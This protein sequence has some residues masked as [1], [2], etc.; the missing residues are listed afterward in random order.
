MTAS[1]AGGESVVEDSGC[2]A[3]DR[4]A[5][6]ACAASAWKCPNESANWTASA[7]SASREPCLT[8]DRNQFMP[9]TTST[10]VF[11]DLPDDSRCYSITSQQSLTCVNGICRPL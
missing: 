9:A 5:G 6:A 3:A 11:R 8:F 10:R 4:F 1:G 2:A 7:N